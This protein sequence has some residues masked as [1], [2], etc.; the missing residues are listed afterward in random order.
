MQSVI[1][2]KLDAKMAT[3]RNGAPKQLNRKLCKS[4]LSPPATAASAA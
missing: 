3:L 4:D 2:P 1:L